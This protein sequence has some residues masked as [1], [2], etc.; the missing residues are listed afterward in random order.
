MS[1]SLPGEEMA[2]KMNPGDSEKYTMCMDV[3]ATGTHLNLGAM[4]RGGLQ[5]LHPPVLV[6]PA[7]V[8]QMP[9]R[10]MAP[11]V[12]QQSTS[13]MVQPH[14]TFASKAKAGLAHQEQSV[15]QKS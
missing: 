2:I 3:C 8:C 12:N 1:S 11:I 7:S 15:N 5:N 6:I 4:I 10:G 9:L 13:L 14:L